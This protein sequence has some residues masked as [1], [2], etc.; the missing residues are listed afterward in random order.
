MVKDKDQTEISEFG[1]SWYK[2]FLKDLDPMIFKHCLFY[3][4]QST[5][6]CKFT[7]DTTFFACVKDLQKLVSR[8][9]HDSRSVIEWFESNYM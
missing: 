1:Q 5:G 9:E 8:L 4:G 6:N 2:E 7:D 3:L